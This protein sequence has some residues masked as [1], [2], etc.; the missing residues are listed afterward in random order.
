MPPCMI[1]IERLRTQQL[2][3]AASTDIDLDAI[4]SDVDTAEQCRQHR[5]YLIGR[6]GSEVLR[7]PDGHGRSAGAVR[8]KAAELAREWEL[9]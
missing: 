1:G 9:N 4:G 5:S 3:E 8:I 7:D 2:D 6:Q